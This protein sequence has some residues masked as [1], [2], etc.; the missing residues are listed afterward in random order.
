M[1][2]R[3]RFCHRILTH[4]RRLASFRCPLCFVTF[5][6][7][8]CVRACMWGTHTKKRS[9]RFWA[10]RCVERALWLIG[11]AAVRTSDDAPLPLSL[12][13]CAK[14]FRTQD[15]VVLTHSLA[16]SLAHARTHTLV[17]HVRVH[18]C[19][20]PKQC[21]CIHWKYSR[22]EWNSMNAH[23]HKLTHTHTTIYIYTRLYFCLCGWGGGRVGGCWGPLTHLRQVVLLLGCSRGC[24][25]CVDI[26]RTRVI[27]RADPQNAR[28]CPTHTKYAE[29]A[30][31]GGGRGAWR[32]QLTD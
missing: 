25:C 1:R 29:L 19:V 13:A 27:L 2:A 26:T 23:T 10:H 5:A 22:T 31:V 12:R 16:H 14:G 18:V 8:A 28:V 7:I 32:G 9:H 17:V 4:R 21:I 3:G 11:T 24:C 6:T 20:S 30:P 15:G